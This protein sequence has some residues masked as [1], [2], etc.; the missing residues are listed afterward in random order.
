MQTQIKRLDYIPEGRYCSQCHFRTEETEFG[1]GGQLVKQWY[2]GSIFCRDPVTGEQ[3]PCNI[4][5]QQLALCGLDGRYFEEQKTVE[6]A[7]VIELIKST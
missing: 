3:M 1:P 2:C 6:T 4:S 5:R 7:P